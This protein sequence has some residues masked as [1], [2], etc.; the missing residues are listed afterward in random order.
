LILKVV[1]D[2]SDTTAQINHT[3]NFES[4]SQGRLDLGSGKTHSKSWLPNS[5]VDGP[6]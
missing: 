1:S 2:I 6:N 5:T 4:N 3:R